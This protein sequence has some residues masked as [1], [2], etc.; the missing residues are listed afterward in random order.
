MMNKRFV[1]D[2][3]KA[4]MQTWVVSVVS[5]DFQV[6][7]HILLLFLFSLHLYKLI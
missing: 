2:L 7:A 1:T 4:V 5:L 3:S 6:R